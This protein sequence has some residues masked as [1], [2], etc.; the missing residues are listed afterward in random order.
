MLKSK[1]NH[2][3]NEK[4]TYG[5]GENISKWGTWHRTNFQNKQTAYTA[6]QQQQKILIKNRR[7]K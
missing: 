7:P 6:Q 1:E 5:M 2:K 4:K 3:E